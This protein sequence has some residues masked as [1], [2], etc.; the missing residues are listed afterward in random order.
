MNMEICI[1]SQIMRNLSLIGEHL[2]L[3][4]WTIVI[5][6]KATI[7]VPFLLLCSISKRFVEYIFSRQDIS[8]EANKVFN[9]DIDK[10]FVN[11]E[12][13]KKFENYINRQKVAIETVDEILFFNNIGRA[14]GNDELSSLIKH[15]SGNY[16]D[17]DLQSLTDAISIYV[18][19][20]IS[21]SNDDNMFKK[22]V[23]FI[24]KNFTHL[25][26][27]KENLTLLADKGLEIYEKILQSG[28]FRIQSEDLLLDTV[29]FLAK[30]DIEF[31]HL[32]EYVHLESCTKDHIEALLALVK[33]H[34]SDHRILVVLDA[35]ERRFSKELPL[36]NTI[37]NKR[38][39]Q[40]GILRIKFEFKNGMFRNE[41]KKDNVKIDYSSNEGDSY[42]KS[43]PYNILKD[44]SDHYS[45]KDEKDSWISVSLKDGRSFILQGYAIQSRMDWENNFLQSWV[46]EGHTKDGD[47]IKLDKHNFEP[48]RKGEIRTFEINPTQEIIKVV[49]KQ[50]DINTSN[51]YYLDLCRFDVFGYIT[52]ETE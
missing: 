26:N 23:N 42:N 1:D 51:R 27:S 34:F 32:L 8:N 4:K 25:A 50:T 47:V 6:G 14:I 43:D 10:N 5:N 49:L 21:N 33:N 36:I 20:F 11:D 28:D 15:R 41:Y 35:F 9:I 18:T 29:T 19:K 38:Y 39:A 24:A 7:E 31:I 2:S 48:F 52:T 16:I 22:E 37:G 13:L 46:L 44:N 12:L 3:D 45:S 17:G 30:I 40:E